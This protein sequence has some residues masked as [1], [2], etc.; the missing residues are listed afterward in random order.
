MK[1]LVRTLALAL[2][3]LLAAPAGAAPGTYP[4]ASPADL[5]VPFGQQ[6]HAF[7]YVLN[8]LRFQPV[9]DVGELA[10]DPDTAI[11]IV[12]GDVAV[13]DRVPGGLGN[14]VKNGG[15]LL[16]ATDRAVRSGPLVDHFGV[17]VDG[18]A[19][20]LMAGDAPQAY[21]GLEECPFAQPIP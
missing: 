1:R 15:A 12:F 6:T 4:A 5:A 3:P 21:R 17:R 13:L 11:L 10:R 2:L 18:R 9:K 8:D 14:F 16:V 7:R 19:V 20:R